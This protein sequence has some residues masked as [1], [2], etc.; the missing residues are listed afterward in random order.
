MSCKAS[1][2]HAASSLIAMLASASL[3]AATAGLPFTEDFS[4]T[5]LNNTTLTN[6]NWSTEEQAVFMAWSANFPTSAAEENAGSEADDT[7]SVILGDVDNDGDLDLIAGN[8]AVASVLYVNNG[9]GSFTWSQALDTNDTRSVILGDVDGDGDLDLVT[10]VSNQANRLYLN[11]GGVFL[12]SIAI[13]TDADDTRSVNLGDVDGDGDLDLVAGA[14]INTQATKLYLNNGSGIFSSSGTAIGSV[15]DI[16]TGTVLVDVDGDS[17]LDLVAVN[18]NQTNRLY[19]N[20]GSG[21]FS[22]SGLPIGSDADD[23]SSVTAGDVDGDGDMDIVVGNIAQPNRLYF[24]SAGVFGSNGVAI[25]TETDTTTSV[26]LRDDDSDG[27]LDLFVG[28]SA[29]AEENKRYINDGAGGFS[30]VGEDVGAARETF[31]LVLGD[32]DSDGDFDVIA[33]NNGANRRF[34]S[35]GRSGFAVNGKAIGSETDNTMAVVLGDVNG[36]DDIDI[37]TGNAGQTNKLYLNDGTGGFPVDGVDIGSETDSTYSV[38]LADVD[39]VSGLDIIVGNWGATNKLYLNDGSGGFPASGADIGDPG[40]LD[41]DATTS[42]ALMD[43]NGDTY[44]DIVVGNWGVTNKFYVNDVA[45]AGDFS[46]AG[47]DIGS[48]TDNTRSIALGDIAGTSDLDLIV[49]NSGL[50]NKLYTHNGV[51]GFS[52]GANIG[53]DVDDNRSIVL[54]DV[55]GVNGLDLIAGNSS[56]L[57]KLYLNDG[58][59]GFPASGTDIGVEMDITTS[60][61]LMDVDGDG[62]DDLLVGN[63]GETSKRYLNNGSGSFSV[64]GAVLSPGNNA[65][66]RGLAVGDIDSDGDGDLVAAEYGQTNKVYRNVIHQSHLGRVVSLKVNDAET[67]IRGV[68]LTAVSTVNTDATRN[69]GIDYFLS[70]TGGVKWH[71]VKSGQVFTFPDAGSN[72]LRWKAEMYSLSPVRTPVLNSVLVSI[73]NPPVITSDGGGASASVNVVANQTSVTT[74]KASDVDN[75]ALAYGIIGGDDAT[76]FSI[77]SASGKLTFIVAPS[78]EAPTDSNGDNVYHVRVMV[79]DSG[80]GNPT[81]T[82]DIFVT[83]TRAVAASGGGGGGGTSSMWWLGFLVLLVVIRT[84]RSLMN[85]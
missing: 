53:T 55:D 1:F 75:G 85:F 45:G 73:N 72:D 27:D 70:N 32:V 79:E 30:T 22:V 26:V 19:T 65:I 82:Q 41:K 16:T 60:M 23:S 76:K 46:V 11:D 59:G 62:D 14:G 44:L 20:N 64:P 68:V 50:E 15:A 37:I 51:G 6:A 74:V 31:S 42:L 49:G 13:G 58:S 4:D 38:V 24:N 10:G 5:A 63:Y 21:G 66:T 69:T 67:N 83:V 17:D 36:D 3:Y 8:S 40:S 71:Q 35:D 81:D 29:L 84:R 33:G 47:V 52:A 28:N 25:G 56:G 57:N 34:L 48:E 61:V 78:F 9:S 2:I 77:D 12:G 43:V 18:S 7:R 54:G 80:A 39:G